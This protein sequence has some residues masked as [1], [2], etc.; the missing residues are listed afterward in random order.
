M[1]KSIPQS[2]T[3][4]PVSAHRRHLPP[5]PNK[6]LSI[7]AILSL[8]Y[9]L[10]T[11]WP[12]W[13]LGQHN[14]KKEDRVLQTTLGKIGWKWISDGR[15]VIPPLLVAVS[16][17]P[18]PDVSCLDDVRAHASPQP[19]TSL[20]A[21]PARPRDYRVGFLIRLLQ[22]QRYFFMFILRIILLY[23]E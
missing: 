9:Y 12:R 10:I 17:A 4:L 22:F 20:L 8:S 6:S 16:K 18:R 15:H 3:A 5:P 21:L 14:D 2:H 13:D 1:V 11:S 7:Y 23:S 19:I